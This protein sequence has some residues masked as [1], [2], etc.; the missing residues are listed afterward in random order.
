MLN[1][2][3]LKGIDPFAAAVRSITEP[4]PVHAALRAAGPLVQVDAPAGGRAW[5]V[6][7]N[8]LAREVLLDPRISKDPR[9][10]ASRLGPLHRRT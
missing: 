3:Y 4:D 8:A 1:A 5:I 7:D 9:V 10:R 6:T 2:P